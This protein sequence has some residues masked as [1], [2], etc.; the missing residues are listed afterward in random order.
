MSEKKVLSTPTIGN[1]ST[2]RKTTKT[3]KENL[4]KLGWFHMDKKGTL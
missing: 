1:I 3:R 2:D 4:D